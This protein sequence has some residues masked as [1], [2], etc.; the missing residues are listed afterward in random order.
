MKVTDIIVKCLF[1]EGIT[2]VFGYPGGMVTHVYDS[3]AKH[4]GIKINST[5]HEQAAA[6]AAEGYSRITNNF[7]VAFA[8]SGPGA[9]NLITGIGSAYFDS[10]PCLYITGQVNSYESNSDGYSRQMGFQ[11]TDIISMVK[12]IT[13]YC[14]YIDNA[15]DI[16]E[17]LE[18][19]ITIA[20]SG[21]KGPV[22]LDIPMNIQRGDIEYR[23]LNIDKT[24]ESNKLN[25]SDID[26]VIELINNSE[27]PVLLAGG[28]LRLSGAVDELRK[29]VELTDIPVVYSM[30][31]KDALSEDNESNYGLI[32]AYGNRYGNYILAN[33][34]LIISL[35]SRLD[36]RQTG[37][38]TSF[39]RQ[40][41]IIRV[42]IDANE[43]RRNI[44]N[45]EVKINCDVKSFLEEWI[46]RGKDSSIKEKYDWLS[47]CK[48]IKS[49]YAD[50][51]N[52]Y[53]PNT[54][55]NSISKKLPEDAVIT[56]DVGQNQVW[57]SQSFAVKENQRVLTCGGMGAMGFSLP[58]AIGASYATDGIVYAF[59]GDG[60]VQMNI[61]E[62]QFLAR[63][64]PNVKIIMLN[65]SSLGMIRHFQELY[66]DKKYVG[67]TANGDYTV[68]NFKKVVEGYGIEFRSIKSIDGIDSIEELL[69]KSGSA[70]I[71]I[72][73]ED[74]T[75]ACPK[76]SMGHPIEDQEPLLD[77]DE[78]DCNMIIPVYGDE[79]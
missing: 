17:E 48:N 18:K 22:L 35:G 2:D 3:F 66:F 74:E 11:E 68:P 64:N 34:D 26:S 27:R 45:D 54:F 44:K 67:T 15:D 57:I 52:S 50:S 53:M 8:T 12:P 13:K 6:F 70:F 60:G 59:C 71:E 76:L 30:M 38:L 56:T 1:E 40:A 9:T 62:L 16:I 25:S 69:T 28:G 31:G 55:I 39:A 72:L 29:I 79:K 20:T 78:L 46:K 41:K 19:A 58:A 65:N 7:G 4:E 75:Y 37:N 23:P 73:L 49:K 51:T 14:R 42:E 10:I 61:Q 21:R 47:Y 24:K 5:Y 43:L 77:R 33:S 36:N 32:G 63:E